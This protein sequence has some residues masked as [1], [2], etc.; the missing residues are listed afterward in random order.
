MTKQ[1]AQYIKEIRSGKITACKWAKLAVDR[2]VR[3]MEKQTDP[4]F[5]FFYDPAAAN[6]AIVFIELLKHSKGEW[7]GKNLVLE[8]WQHFITCCLFG[9]KRKD[10]K[11]RRFRKAYIEVARKNGKSTWAAGIGNYMFIADGE[12]GAECYTAATKREQATICHKEAELQIRGNPTLS[13]LVQIYKLNLSI[14]TTGAKFVPLS[15]DSKTQDGLNPHFGLMDEYHAHP[16]DELME[17][18]KTGMGSRRQPMLLIITTAGFNVS[19]PCHLEHEFAQSVLEG[20]KSDDQFFCIM[21]TLDQG[22]DWADSS[23]WIKANPN[24]GVSVYPDF[25]KSQVEEAVKSP[26]KQNQVKVKN[27]N[28]WCTSET[29]WMTDEAWMACAAW[30]DA[31]DLAGRE[32]YGALDLSTSLDITALL[33]DFPPVIDGE[34]HKMLARF[35]MPGDNVREKERKDK[36]PYSAWIEAGLITP[37]PG[38]VIDYDFIE[39]DIQE[40]REK[41]DII[42]IA[43]DPWNS[44][45]I[46]NH[47]TE[48]G[49]TMVPIRQQF[50]GMAAFTKQFERSVLGQELTHNGHP[51]LRWM[52]SCVEIKSD[53]QGNVMP[54]KPE[55]N[56]SGKRIDGIVAWIMAHG[57]A[58]LAEGDD[59][60]SAYNKQELFVL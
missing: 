33:F 19:C 5:P 38:N 22:D 53:R 24:I 43:F 47:L 34:P 29:R 45:A 10:N 17:V 28:M 26:Q 30:Y 54:M 18:V 25:I 44:S 6:R 40:L 48:S 50:S 21:Y 20:S 56:K 51:I 16:T 49:L 39:H 35:Y 32:C 1:G 2:H 36:V 46:V 31:A 42:E 15:S 12:A 58:L 37:T 9:W 4:A 8:P 23:V 3:E 7:A 60:K 57:R 52:M 59:Q 14:V 11:F 27:L 41:H 55:R 13:A